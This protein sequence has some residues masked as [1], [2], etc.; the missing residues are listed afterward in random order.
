MLDST[1]SFISSC[2][3][4]GVNAT[5]SFVAYE[6]YMSIIEPDT[7]NTSQMNDMA[8]QGQIDQYKRGNREARGRQEGGKREAKRCKRAC[9]APDCALR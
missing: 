9:C 8:Q 3:A 1:A 4:S 2:V 5:T 6:T 7:N